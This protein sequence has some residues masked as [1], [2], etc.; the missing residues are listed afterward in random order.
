VVDQERDVRGTENLA[1]FVVRS[2][3]GVYQPMSVNGG[4]DGDE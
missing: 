4:S 3:S 2:G 1:R